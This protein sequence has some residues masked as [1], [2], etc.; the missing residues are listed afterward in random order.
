MLVLEDRFTK[1]GVDMAGRRVTLRYIP[2]RRAT[3]KKKAVARRR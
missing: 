2:K 3:S 1:G